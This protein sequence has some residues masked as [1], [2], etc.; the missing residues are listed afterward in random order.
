MTVTANATVGSLN[1][2]TQTTGNLGTLTINENVTLTVNGATTLY[3]AS[4]AVNASINGFG[5]LTTSQ[6]N[7][8]NDVNPGTNGTYTHTLVITN[9]NINVSGDLNI[10]SERGGSSSQL[11]NGVL[12]IVSGTVTVNGT[13]ST[14]NDRSVNTATL[15]LGNS[16]PTLI[17]NG[18]TP[19]TI[20][21]TSTITLNGTELL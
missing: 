19:F 4:A 5:T 17:L 11:S 9:T 10:Q 20:S 21:G 15:T 6:L 3:N 2:S 13:V 1:F 16:S 12:N 14:D 18:A 8:G 7:I